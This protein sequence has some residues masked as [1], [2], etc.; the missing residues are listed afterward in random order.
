[1][2]KASLIHPAC[3][4]LVRGGGEGKRERESV[5]QASVGWLPGDTAMDRHWQGNILFAWTQKPRNLDLT[6][7]YASRAPCSKNLE[8]TSKL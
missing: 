7:G 6:Y 4:F 5:V 2:E 8:G 1:M 3:S